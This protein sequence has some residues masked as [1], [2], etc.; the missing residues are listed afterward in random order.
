MFLF[1]CFSKDI[2]HLHVQ[3]KNLTYLTISRYV[4][5]HN[6]LWG[7]GIDQ[8]NTGSV[9]VFWFC[10]LTLRSVLYDMNNIKIYINDD[11]QQILF[12]AKICKISI[13]LYRP[14]WSCIF[15]SYTFWLNLPYSSF[16]TW[17]RTHSSNQDVSF[18]DHLRVTIGV[19]L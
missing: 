10:H 3:K 9:D 14:Y 1:L 18:S 19:S 8:M 11:R 4:L 17:N 13:L 12:S 2:D 16:V 15:F 5:L 6:T 7:F